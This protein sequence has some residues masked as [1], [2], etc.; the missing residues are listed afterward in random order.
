MKAI[1]QNTH[2][3]DLYTKYIFWAPK[4]HIFQWYTK[5]NFLGYRALAKTDDGNPA[6]TWGKTL[7]VLCPMALSVS[8]QK[9][10]VVVHFPRVEV[11]CLNGYPMS[12]LLRELSSIVLRS[13]TVCTKMCLLWLTIN[14]TLNNCTLHYWV[15]CLNYFILL[16]FLC[17]HI[18]VLLLT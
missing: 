4:Y 6:L 9:Y 13:F 10:Q 2:Y 15:P 5:Y 11:W 8:V 3:M 18:R 12:V 7:E 14:I 17:R 16:S 1:Y